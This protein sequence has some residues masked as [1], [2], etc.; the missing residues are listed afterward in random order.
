[1]DAAAKEIQK[2]GCSK[3]GFL[4]TKQTMEFGFFQR[5]FAGHGIETIIPEQEERDYV[6]RVIWEELVHGK[7]TDKAR[8]GYKIII[9]KLVEKGV[10]GIILGCTEIPLLI[11]QNDS[12]VRIYDTTAIHARAILDYAME[13]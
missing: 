11:K 13:G 1:M 7:I 12:P 9:Q 2:D 10:Q 3:A 5:A 6:N 4:G 8:Q